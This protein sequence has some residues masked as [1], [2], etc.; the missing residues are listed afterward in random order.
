VAE[1]VLGKGE[2]L[3]PMQIKVDERQEQGTASSGGTGH[4]RRRAERSAVSGRG[5][6]PSSQLGEQDAAGGAS[7]RAAV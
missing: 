4:G 6:W 7:T 1:L 5:N 2:K 3:R